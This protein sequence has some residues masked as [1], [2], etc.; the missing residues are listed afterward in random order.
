MRPLRANL[1][2]WP[3]GCR[4]RRT[5][6]ACWLP[7][8]ARSLARPS[9]SATAEFPDPIRLELA[10]APID[11]SDVFL[12]HKTTHRAVYA[13][14]QADCRE[15]DDVL[16]YNQ[17]GEVTETTLATSWSAAART[18]GRRRCLADCWRGPIA[19]DCWPKARSASAW[20]RWKCC[21]SA[22]SCTSSTPCGFGGRLGLSVRAMLDHSPQDSIPWAALPRRRFRDKIKSLNG[23][24]S[25]SS[26]DHCHAHYHAHSRPFRHAARPGGRHVRPHDFEGATYHAGRQAV[27]SRGLSRQQPR[28]GFSD[29]GQFAL[30]GR[31][32]RHVDARDIL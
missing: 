27:L 11:A 12:Y 2:P 16:L 19:P 1:P 30:G 25:P 4:P 26:F 28:G 24:S 8:T 5:R 10:A 32:P 13:A 3:R 21:A 15:G 14:A 17:R 29:L 18:C 20:F 23:L 7:A 6:S 22:T 31:V 9:R